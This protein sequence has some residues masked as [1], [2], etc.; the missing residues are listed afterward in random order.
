MNLINIFG[1]YLNNLQFSFILYGG[2]AAALLALC[3]L[4]WRRSAAGKV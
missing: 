2:L 1:R 4:G 3:W